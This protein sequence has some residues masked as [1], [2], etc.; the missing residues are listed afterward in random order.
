MAATNHASSWGRLEGEGGEGAA[1]GRQGGMIHVGHERSEKH[2]GAISREQ[3]SYSHLMGGPMGWAVNG[4]G[5]AK[6]IGGG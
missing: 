1:W 3:E 5:G 6:E 2:I 4:E